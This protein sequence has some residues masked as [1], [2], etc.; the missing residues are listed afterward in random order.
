MNLLQKKIIKNIQ[1]TSKIYNAKAIVLV[2]LTIVVVVV[3]VIMKKAL[4]NK[5]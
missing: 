2:I 3:I 4:M 1:S 5:I